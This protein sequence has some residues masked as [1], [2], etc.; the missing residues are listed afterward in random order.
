M[1]I[2]WFL[3][4]VL[5]W[6]LTLLTAM[7]A[8]RLDGGWRQSLL[9]AAEFL[10][11]ALAFVVAC[12]VPYTAGVED[13]RIVAL[14]LVIVLPAALLLGIALS[15]VEYSVLGRRFGFRTDL[16]RSLWIGKG[17]TFRFTRDAP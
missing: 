7:T 2:L 6:N 14:L 17:G 11:L 9:L 12:V 1:A 16:R 15:F 5:V 4:L 3:G 13:A 8:G 10:L